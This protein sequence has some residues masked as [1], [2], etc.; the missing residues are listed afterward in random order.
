MLK[1]IWKVMVTKLPLLQ[2][3]AIPIWNRK[4]TAAIANMIHAAGL[5][6]KLTDDPLFHEV[7]KLA[8]CAGTTYKPPSRQQVAGPLL[9]ANF[10]ATL[11]AGLVELWKD[12]YIFGIAA[13]W[14]MVQL[15]KNSHF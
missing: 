6:F 11:E 5:P 7:I 4:L 13:I 9:E 2:G 1:N 3:G 12:A 10:Q 14:V 15:S 8:M